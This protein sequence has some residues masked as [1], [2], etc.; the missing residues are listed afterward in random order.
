MD[1]V[2]FR[3]LL[4]PALPF[5]QVYDR[6]VLTDPTCDAH[7]LW[8]INASKNCSFLL[9]YGKSFYVHAKCFISVS[10]THLTLPTI[11]RV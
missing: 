8:T 5:K 7:C 11:L 2:E 3:I 4:T 9:S 6:F 1:L 10:Y